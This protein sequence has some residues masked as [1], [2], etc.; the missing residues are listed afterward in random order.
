MKKIVLLIE[1]N[2][3]DEAL[4]LRTLRING[5]VDKVVVTHDGAEALDFLAREGAP[6]PRLILLD[7]KLPKVDG[8]QVLRRIREC[9]RTALLPVVLLST[10]SEEK[11]IAAGYRLGANGYVRKLVDF[12]RFSEAV[13]C[14][15]SYWLE[16][17]EPPPSPVAAG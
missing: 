16:V 15:L 8:L 4:M 13:Q 10:S 1:D 9:P 3:D 12:E 11:D 5:G 14:I 2:P 7:L 6:P 17:N